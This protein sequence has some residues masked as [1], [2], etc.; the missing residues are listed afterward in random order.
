[1]YINL[2]K[3]DS[4]IVKAWSQAYMYMDWTTIIDSWNPNIL[5]F[6]KYKSIE[7]YALYGMHDRNCYNDLI[8]CL[9]RNNVSIIV[10]CEPVYSNHPWKTIQLYSVNLYWGGLFIQVKI[11]NCNYV[12][13]S[14][15]TI[16]IKCDLTKWWSH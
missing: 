1:M 16:I 11:L 14:G 10:V 3:V 2:W 15:F 13:L 4:W 9:T 5:K 7:K 6:V 8:T 12:E